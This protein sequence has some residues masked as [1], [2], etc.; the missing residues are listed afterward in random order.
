MRTER[1]FHPWHEWECYKCGFY[2]TSPPDGMTK[3]EAK[4][5]YADFLS[6]SDRF[7]AAMERVSQEWP[8]SCEHFLTNENI[9]RVAWLG[10]AAMCIETGVSSFY[11]AGFMLLDLP[12]Q[13]KANETAQKFLT[14]WL[15]DGKKDTGICERVAQAR[16][17]K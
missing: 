16:L 10:Q 6:D 5:S 4:K 11:R 17:F 9:N 3:D 8:K 12:N 1:I 15:S 7:E 13:N 14:R 2:D